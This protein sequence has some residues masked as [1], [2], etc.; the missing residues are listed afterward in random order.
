MEIHDAR[1]VYT[2]GC[3][4]FRAR[5]SS[6]MHEKFRRWIVAG[7]LITC[8]AGRAR[9]DLN[10]AGEDL[11]LD[12]S[13]RFGAF[14]RGHGEVR[15]H[16]FVAP[17]DF[18]KGVAFDSASSLP[19][20]FAGNPWTQSLAHFDAES[21]ETRLEFILPI[22]GFGSMSGGT[23]LYSGRACRFR[24]GFGAASTDP[25]QGSSALEIRVYRR[26]TMEWVDTLRWELPGPSEP[27]FGD[28]ARG[29]IVSY[30]PGHQL[31]TRIALARNTEDGGAT[32]YHVEH[33][34]LRADLV[35]GV[36]GVGYVD[37]RDGDYD[38]RSDLQER[39]EGTDAADAESFV[40]TRL[41]HW[42]F[43]GPEPG[44]EWLAGDRGQLPRAVAS[45]TQAP[46]FRGQ[47]A[48]IDHIDPP[49][50][51]LI[52]ADAEANGTPNVVCRRGSVRLW[53][54]P[55]WS[56]ST[57]PFGFGRLFELGSWTP[58]GSRGLWLLRFGDTPSP[59][60]VFD[61]QSDGVT[62]RFLEF[63]GPWSQQWHQ[64]VLTY[65]PDGSN[66]Y[67]D[68]LPAATGS[69]PFLFP[70][71][72]VRRI[73]G[74]KIG[75]DF[76][77]HQARG[78]FDDIETFNFEL[79]AAA[80]QR[81]YTM[82]TTA[83]SGDS[84]DSR[85][86]VPVA[87]M[88]S[89]RV[90]SEGG[91]GASSS[92]IEIGSTVFTP[93]TGMGVVRLNPDGS[94]I[95]QRTFGASQ[96]AALRDHLDATGHG[97]ILLMTIHME[98]PGLSPDLDFQLWKLGF[99][100]HFS[101]NPGCAWI[102]IAQ[103]GQGRSWA[104]RYS[105][106]TEEEVSAC[107]VDFDLAAYRAADEAGR[108]AMAI[109]AAGTPVAAPLYVINVDDQPA[110]RST[111]LDRPHFTG[112]PAPP[113]SSALAP[114]S[115]RI[116]AVSAAL[117]S[118]NPTDFLELDHS[119]ELR[120]H[121]TLD[122][123][124]NDMNQN[125]I[126]LARYVHDRIELVDWLDYHAEIQ[127]SV[128]LEHGG[129]NR[130]ALGVLMEGRGSPVEQCALLVYLLRAAG[131]P[132]TYVFPNGDGSK[133]GRDAVE[134][135]LR[136]RVSEVPEIP[137]WIPLS[138][139]WVAAH[140]DGAWRYLFP[141][142]K[143]VEVVE[144]H[145]VRD[146][147]PAEWGGM[148]DWTRGFLENDGEIE[149]L[150]RE[151]GSD[152]PMILFERF[153]INQLRSRRES[154]DE[155]GMRY[156]IRTR[157]RAAWNDFAAPESVPDNVELVESLLA[158]L[159][160][161]N[162]IQ[163]EFLSE[164]HPGRVLDT[165]PMRIAEI[166]GRRL[167]LRFER[168]AHDRH[169]MILTLGRAHP[170]A[171]D[172][173]DFQAIHV[174][175]VAAPGTWANRRTSRVGLDADDDRILARVT[176]HRSRHLPWTAPMEENDWNHQYYETG[177]AS[178]GILF[179]TETPFRKGDTVALCIN[180]GL[181]SRAM[182]DA[183][184][185]AILAHHN[186]LES[187]PE[188]QPDPDVYLGSV[189]NLLGTSYW[190]DR[191]RFAGFAQRLFKIRRVSEFGYGYAV[192]KAARDAAGQLVNNGEIQ[193]SI[194]VLDIVS[195]GRAEL[196]N[197]TVHPGSGED[198]LSAQFDYFL[199]ESLQGSA[200]EHDAINSYFNKSDAVS[201]VKL[202]QSSGSGGFRHVTEDNLHEV[203]PA[204]GMHSEEIADITENHFRS[205]SGREFREGYVNVHPVQ[206]GEFRGVGAFLI[207]RHGAA[208]AHVGRVD[209]HNGGI[210]GSP[211]PVNMINPRWGISKDGRYHILFD[212]NQVPVE[213]HLVESFDEIYRRLVGGVAV[214]N[215]EFQNLVNYIHA[216][217][218]ISGAA[219]GTAAGQAAAM[220]V[221]FE[222]GANAR[223]TGWFRTLAHKI[224]DPVDA[225]SG[226]FFIDEVD[227]DVAGPLPF[228]LRR[229]Y[230]SQQIA[231][232]PFGYG[233]NLGL[234]P[235]L[236]VSED[237]D[238]IYA[239][240]P[241][242]AV[243]AYRRVN[244]TLWKPSL[245]DNPQLSNHTES[246]AGARAN[247]MNSSIEKSA[248]SNGQDAYRL[249]AAD[250]G[251]RLFRV[252]SFPANNGMDRERPYLESW[253]DPNGNEIRFRFGDDPA[254]TDYGQLRRIE[255]GTGRYI[256]LRYNHLGFITETFSDDGRHFHYE[257][258]RFGDLRRVI[259]PDD[260][261][262]SYDYEIVDSNWD[263]EPVRVSSHLLIRETRPGGRVLENVYD[264]HR[265]VVE[266]S[267]TVGSDQR[268]HP[269]AQFVYQHDLPPDS[270]VPHALTGH[271]VVVDAL[272]HATRYDY[273]HNRITRV[274]DPTGGVL[275]QIWHNDDSGLPGYP[276]SLWKRKDPRGLWT[277]FFYDHRGNVVRMV[278]TG[279][280]DGD[281]VAANGESVEWTFAYDSN[282]RLIQERSPDGLRA[283]Y[284]YDPD[285]PFSVSRIRRYA[286]ETLVNETRRTYHSVAAVPGDS[287]NT[288]L[289]GAF[290]MLQRE[291]IAA[292]SPDSAVTEW[293][294][295]ARGFVTRRIRFT[296][297]DDPDEIIEF[298]RNAR[299]Q[300]VQRIEPDG[301]TIRLDRDWRGNVV[302]RHVFGPAQSEP[303]AVER[304]H[305][306]AN[307]ELVWRDGPRSDPEDYVFVRYDAAGRPV[308]T[309]EWQSR[310]RAGQEGVEAVPG[311]NRFST[312][313]REFDHAGN[314]VRT[315]NPLGGLTT[316]TFDG[317]GRVI[318]R[319]QFLDEDESVPVATELFEYEPGPGGKV[320]RHVDSAGGVT[321]TFYND[322]GQ[323]RRIVRPD[324]AS[325]EWRYHLDGRLR[326]SIQ[327]NGAW[328]ESTYQLPGRTEFRV[329][330]AA[331][332]SRVGLERFAF[333]RRGNL[334]R[335]E[336]AAGFFREQTFDGLNRLISDSGWAADSTG[337]VTRYRHDLENRTRTV[338]HPNGDR[339]STKS[340]SLGR[341]LEH[342]SFNDTGELV[343]HRSAEY[344]ADHH[345]F[346][347]TVGSGSDSVRRLVLT[348]TRGQTVLT[349]IIGES[350]SSV[351]E[352]DVAGNLV[353]VTDEL[354]RTTVFER[355]SL[356]RLRR[357]I[358]PDGTGVSYRYDASG[359]LVRMNLPDQSAWHAEYDV[360]GR[361]TRQYLENAGVVSGTVHRTYFADGP[362]VGLPASEIDARQV[363]TTFVYDNLRRIR[364]SNAVGPFPEHGMVTEYHYDARGLLIQLDQ[365]S[366][367]SVVERTS[368]RNQFDASRRLIDQT[369][370]TTEG[371][372]IEVH[373]R[374]RQTWDDAGRRNSLESMVHDDLKLTF[375][376]RADGRLTRV[377]C[378]DL[379]FSYEYD[380]GGRLSARRNPFRT[381]VV[382]DRDSN[383]RPRRIVTTDSPGLETF[384]DESI[385]WF[386]DG[387]VQAHSITR[388]GDVSHTDS[389][390]YTYDTR[391]RLV[392]EEWRPNGNGP[393][394]I[395]YHFDTAGGGALA[396]AAYSGS[397]QAHTR[398]TSD[399]AGLFGQILD[400]DWS[401]GEWC[402]PVAGRAPGAVSVDVFLDNAPM[403]SVPVDRSNP[404]GSWKTPV[405]FP[406]GTHRLDV[407]AIPA[408]LSEVADPVESDYTFHAES[409][410]H[411][412]RAFDASG[413]L[414]SQNRSDGRTQTLRW[415]PLGRL[416]EVLEL[417]PSENG[418]R[419][420][421]LYDGLGRRIQT[422]FQSLNAGN[423]EGAPIITDV[424][425]DPSHEFLEVSVLERE[426][427]EIGR[428]FWKIHGPDRDGTHGSHHG[429]GGLEAVVTAGDPSR[430]IGVV[431]TLDGS[432]TGTVEANG[433]ALEW[434]PNRVSGYG[435]HPG[436]EPGSFV[437][438][439]PRSVAGHWLSKRIDP[440]GFY[441]FGARY[442]NPIGGQF[443]SPDPL[444]PAASLDLYAYADGDPINRVDPDG[445]LGRQAVN[446]GKDYIT[447]PILFLPRQALYWSF[448]RWIGGDYLEP[449][450]VKIEAES[451][452]LDQQTTFFINGI[453]NTSDSSEASLA[454]LMEEIENTSGSLVFNP[455]TMNDFKN[456]SFLR[457]VFGNQAVG[458]FRDIIQTLGQGFLGLPDRS[459]RLAADRLSYALKNGDGTPVRFYVHSQGGAIAGAT[460]RYLSY[461]ERQQVD[462]VTFGAALF[463]GST[464]WR[465]QRHEVNVRDLVTFSGAGFGP[466]NLIHTLR[467]LIQRHY[468]V[469]LHWSSQRGATFPHHNFIDSYSQFAK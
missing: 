88:P 337:S 57:G 347:E 98:T 445:R 274:A 276:R 291:V 123:L 51:R 103:T 122:A 377:A 356:G 362:F 433:S 254:S 142:L 27:G 467:S 170:A 180:P 36:F 435:P 313:F 17:L 2:N 30:H 418:H 101:W 193:P 197:G 420:T 10:L 328:T 109:D 192:F 135:L 417:D 150:S 432:V 44:G 270:G 119:P 318:E 189:L 165:G 218:R 38:G 429:T 447:D 390:R 52:Y 284:E 248:P 271:T 241:D 403:A 111:F 386:P 117:N 99:I 237:G 346:I 203:L 370:L 224:H 90:R 455:S 394:S 391:N 290:G 45:V 104:E 345:G 6:S 244:S 15:F 78:R 305:Y 399:P 20:S 421:A 299:G 195:H 132:A 441:W 159:D 69:R 105:G 281:G 358:L 114:G 357:R 12:A 187:D 326:R 174:P 66:L 221:Q 84:A 343:F 234:M 9:A 260:S 64:I 423:D 392:R 266:Q 424:Q 462:L 437:H 216:A 127:R 138:Y 133:L 415:D 29:G 312:T 294:H 246:G 210:A 171:D 74:F 97:T 130:G 309:I 303:V 131:V 124:V 339:S 416:V 267:S 148:S 65:G 209:S 361:Q 365:S 371:G 154:I 295:D 341:F 21:P 264:D 152:Q 458:G 319:R 359:N 402:Q 183:D 252:R 11:A 325:I 67:I 302:A 61:G 223:P 71:E 231:P 381:S 35:L 396:E 100:R 317:L 453:L 331:D 278:H 374:F 443:L 177:V 173:G 162:T 419:W 48:E 156:R 72:S 439:N 40:P 352:F 444:G 363:V 277:E 55:S 87:S 1:S 151:T 53:F 385:S 430:N 143:D 427:G 456:I 256:G 233:W 46:G 23:P 56:G 184:A 307:N 448:F 227:L 369:V 32:I 145:S 128:R 37:Q 229:Q 34:A 134:S 243:I 164:S 225:V 373:S 297:T 412:S 384:V 236:S 340:D 395:D 42:S 323:R 464:G 95:D 463:H 283:E 275:E 457:R 190:R 77:Y 208:G 287:G 324:G 94:L 293:E 311:Q 235:F 129:V 247:S 338:L 5:G 204:I 179:V 185:A 388:F 330:H 137:E 199:L 404:T 285:Y 24:V 349:R 393:A 397:L 113:S 379:E 442:Y 146:V 405:A 175:N 398:V 354:G 222:Q 3:P 263:N 141:W 387:S 63:N 136:L 438:G 333:D 196:F 334:V 176:H 288:S 449:E 320:T 153:L 33:V 410:G 188:S 118:A 466:F 296:G 120:R 301:T 272:G 469:N 139:P 161:F 238:L 14:V 73:D 321:R 414:T 228:S 219:P 434:K 70:G 85:P 186:R 158:R 25:S 242:G 355:D 336:D 220:R 389:R 80:V 342:S 360:A 409:G 214:A 446:Y 58:D 106:S 452:E 426:R 160:L 7:M 400:L 298:V 286:G 255:S 314:Q 68:G 329:T 212:E 261:E 172:G 60:L 82:A 257:Y 211:I 461:S 310:T 121:P 322:R 376:H 181:P 253:T 39:F 91:N 31:H 292:N 163:V 50:S 13:A 166:H 92:R 149:V 407:R 230:L 316:Q 157:E 249:T 273:A 251:I 332:G 250:G 41:A 76:G 351:Q 413:N 8:M 96:S 169:D 126:A 16:S 411:I 81:Y 368:I 43:D 380:S 308:E 348:N 262:V 226:E 327:P 167:F 232:G 401:V 364:Q 378:R 144:G 207:G 454:R 459:A 468:D 289:I 315:R 147:L 269:N 205:S 450:V 382:V 304:F 344:R 436:Y 155:V 217:M 102:G 406:P 79:S 140:V 265:R 62:A 182:L 422:R 125:P 202:L 86:D 306:N 112:E 300:A 367:S 245:D 83:A 282:D 47:S 115:G 215:V 116:H 213:A 259:R 49:L 279:D 110:W 460:A 168:I 375:N 428:R 28:F 108:F 258:D 425:F 200:S 431:T 22:A 18:Q 198:S 383:G 440:T 4:V 89:V 240:D 465:S 178:H 201:A 335:S 280:L 206:S 268:L 194:P 353:S 19:D 408:F 366:E 350:V 191:A 75:S 54:R 93:E 372:L 59:E 451:G 107:E 239:S 26:D